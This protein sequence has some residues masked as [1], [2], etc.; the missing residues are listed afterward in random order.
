MWSLKAGRERNA[1]EISLINNNIV[2]ITPWY[3][4]LDSIINSRKEVLMYD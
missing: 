1:D 4:I 2:N 3:F